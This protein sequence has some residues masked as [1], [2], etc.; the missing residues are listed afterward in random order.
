MKENVCIAIVAPVQP[1]DFFDLLWEGVW[2]ATFDLSSFGVEVQNLTT[3]RADVEG[4]RRILTDLLESGVDAIGLMPAHASALDD[5]IDEHERRGTPVVTVHGDAPA[6]QR[7]A[8]VRALLAQAGALAAEL[9]VKLM[10]CSGRILSFPGSLDQFHYGRR[11]QGFRE[12]LAGCKGT[13]R[14]SAC[15]LSL[16]DLAALPEADQRKVLGQA[17]G[18]YVG[19]HDLPEIAAILEN[20]A[21]HAPCVGFSNTA[22]VRPYL[23]RGVVSAVVDENRHQQGYFAVQ[24]AYEAILKREQHAH[25]GNVRIPNTVIF[26]ANASEMEDSLKDAFEMLVRQRTGI[27]CSYKDKLEQANAQ[28]L[29]LSVTDPLTGLY[30]RRRFEEVMAQEVARALRYGPVSLLLVDVNLFKQ[31]NDRYGHQAGDGALR[32]VA[33]V[34]RSSCRATDTCARLGGDEFAVIL[35]HSNPAAACVVRDRILER[36]ARS[37]V[38]CENGEFAVSLSIGVATLPDDAV[39]AEGL[40]AAADAAMYQAKH[41]SRLT[42]A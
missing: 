29:S 25:P 4:Q 37:R 18:Y 20:L 1:E 17:N 8:F 23:D 12:V 33:G 11:Y 40:I 27:L 3:K 13:V 35:P 24:K 34:L 2:E 22:R 30:N 39:D 15:A 28:L 38:A 42:P 16:D 9:L 5:L 31:V 41:A 14:E 10:G 32:I 19:N 6:S 36:I 26:A 21:I 7:S